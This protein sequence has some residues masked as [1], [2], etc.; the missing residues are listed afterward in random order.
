[1]PL[2]GALTGA[3]TGALL[4]LDAQALTF[5][6]FGVTFYVLEL[7]TSKFSARFFELPNLGQC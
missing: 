6:L 4:L 5:S 1:M 3:L 7:W 2:Q